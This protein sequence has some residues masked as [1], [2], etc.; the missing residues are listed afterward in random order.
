MLIPY[1]DETGEL[2]GLR[3]HKGMGRRDTLVGTPQVYIPRLG[4]ATRAAKFH[5]ASGEDDEE[6]F[7]TV[8]ITEGEFKAAALWQTVGSGRQDGAEPYG[9]AALPGI[10]FG[11]N[12][13]VR[14]VLDDWLRVVKCR[15]VIVAYDNEEK[16]DPALETYKADRRKRFD[17]QIWARYLATDLAVKL[18]VRGEVCVLPEAW[19]N[20]KG[21][22][23]WD[24]ELAKYSNLKPQASGKS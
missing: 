2:I 10:S 1:F 19:R 9:V 21:K 24:G 14:E 17:A 18:H 3:P 8:V 5:R 20:K 15:R 7:Y 16:A 6:Q 4:R 11:K 13:E 12:Y 23:D 22:A